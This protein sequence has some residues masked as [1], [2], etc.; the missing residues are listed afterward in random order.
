MVDNNNFETISDNLSEENIVEK[1]YNENNSN[2]F[3][4]NNEY[5]NQNIAS[6]PIVNPPTIEIEQINY[7]NNDQINYPE[8]MKKRR[9]IKNIIVII[10]SFI[11]IGV[12]IGNEFAQINLKLFSFLI[13]IDD[14]LVFAMAILILCCIFINKNIYVCVIIIPSVLI[15]FGGGFLKMSAM[16][17]FSKHSAFMKFQYILLGVR[18]VAL[19]FVPFIICTEYGRKS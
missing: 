3:N 19:F 9:D 7:N 18:T 6:A 13:L 15:T 10:L 2:N 17:K 14:L 1:P 4:N 8:A 11:L 12:T 16:D 5:Q